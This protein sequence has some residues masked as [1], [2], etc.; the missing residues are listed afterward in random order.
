MAINVKR[1]EAKFTRGDEA[2]CWPWHG[3][4]NSSG[5]GMAWDGSAFRRA[6]RVAYELHTGQAIP[7]GMLVCHTCDNRVCVNPAHLF[8]GTVG[9][10]VRDCA[11]KGRLNSQQPT[12]RA[13]FP[14][15]ENSPFAKLTDAQVSEIRRLSSNGATQRGLASQFGVSRGHIYRL[16]NGLNRAEKGAAV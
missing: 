5:Y 16:V 10:N 2:A 4:K 1:F 11:S 3:T 15:G 8:L 7:A 13:A 14:T 12:H 9:D 6:H